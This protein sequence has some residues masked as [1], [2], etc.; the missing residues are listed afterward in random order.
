MKNIAA[1]IAFLGFAAS[2]VAADNRNLAVVGII[3]QLNKPGTIL[4]EITIG[5]DDGLKV[6]DILVVSRKGKQIGK[7]KIAKCEPDRSIAKIIDVQDGERLRTRD[8]VASK[9]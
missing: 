3:S 5:S 2:A 9:R 1:I 7:V 4:V 6:G 8:H